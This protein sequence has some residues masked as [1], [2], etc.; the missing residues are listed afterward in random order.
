[1]GINFLI[2]ISYLFV[3]IAA[4]FNLTSIID[5]VLFDEVFIQIRMVISLLVFIFWIYTLVYWSKNDKRV[6]QVLLLIFLIGIYSPIYYIMNY[7]QFN[8]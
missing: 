8:G 3:L 5:Y 1:M 7:K 2:L 4:V 6:S